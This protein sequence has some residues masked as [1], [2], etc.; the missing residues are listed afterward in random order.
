M[1][2]HVMEC[3]KCKKEIKED[4][5]FCP[6]CG[7]KFE[8]K[9]KSES[10]LRLDETMNRAILFGFTNGFFHGTMF[11]NDNKTAIKEMDEK[12]KQKGKDAYEFYKNMVKEGYKHMGIKND[13]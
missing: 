8:T 12:M 3:Q 9:F 10:V 7:E 1:D 11:V 6:E 2:R 5:R 13:A 4:A